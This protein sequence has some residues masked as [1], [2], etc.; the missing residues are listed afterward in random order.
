M[1]AA[2]REKP[3]VVQIALCIAALALMLGLMYWTYTN[4]TISGHHIGLWFRELL[5]RPF[6]ALYSLHRPRIGFGKLVDE[7]STLSLYIK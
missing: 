5:L 7:L 6:P 1:P 4:P 2:V 3:F